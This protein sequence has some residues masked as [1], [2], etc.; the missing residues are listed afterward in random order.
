VPDAIVDATY[1]ATINSI[2]NSYFVAGK[3]EQLISGDSTFG[4]I[5][6]QTECIIVDPPRD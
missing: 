5:C 4:E 1:N 3:A 2:E 6:E